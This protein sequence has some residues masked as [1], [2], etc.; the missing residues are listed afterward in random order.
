MN[1]QMQWLQW[2]AE[3]WLIRNT[4]NCGTCQAAMA[5]VRRHEAPE[6]FS[7]GVDLATPDAVC[8]QDRSSLIVS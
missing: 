8:E 7:G 1:D 6:G 4:N 5:L 2:L 3:H